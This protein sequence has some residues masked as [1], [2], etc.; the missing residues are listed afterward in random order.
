MGARAAAVAAIVATCVSCGAMA[1]QRQYIEV[2]NPPE[3]SAAKH[4]AP[5]AS[6]RAVKV[7][8][9]ARATEGHVV[10]SAAHPSQIKH[11]AHVKH[12]IH[13]AS[14]TRAPSKTKT[15]VANRAGSKKHPV[16]TSTHASHV[17]TTRIAK[18][19]PSAPRPQ[20]TLA[21]NA[22]HRAGAEPPIL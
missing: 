1:V 22:P 12:A 13:T 16:S 18:Q 10:A 3:A 7:T 6:K 5:R 14:V 17:T 2:W 9:T 11:A 8:K 15:V 20:P 4:A 19:T 21:K